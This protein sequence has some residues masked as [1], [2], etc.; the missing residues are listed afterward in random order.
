MAVSY[1]ALTRASRSLL[2]RR[3]GYW[4]VGP[5]STVGIYDPV[6][7]PTYL[8]VQDQAET[9][10]CIRSPW[11]VSTARSEGLES[12]SW[13]MAPPLLCMPVPEAQGACWRSVRH[14]PPWQPIPAAGSLQADSIHVPWGEIST[15][16]RC[17]SPL[18]L[19]AQGLQVAS[20]VLL[21]NDGNGV[22]VQ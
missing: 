18:R 1:I 13:E 20:S 5:A 2:M 9:P 12:I 22:A 8:C 16:P 10:D 21:D 11:M 6:D 14:R 4:H 3:T 19:G 17:E 15:R 7:A